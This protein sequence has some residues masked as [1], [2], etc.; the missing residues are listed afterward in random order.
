MKPRA[1]H[2]YPKFESKLRESLFAC[3]MFHTVSTGAVSLL[4][5]GYWM[6]L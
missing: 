4:A 5:G 3:D 6:M 1:R 2:V